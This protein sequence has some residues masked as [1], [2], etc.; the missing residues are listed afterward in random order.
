[1]HYEITRTEFLC[2]QSSN[3]ASDMQAGLVVFGQ[4]VYDASMLA[5]YK[6]NIS[7]RQH[8][9]DTSN[10]ER[11]QSLRPSVHVLMARQCPKLVDVGRGCD[12]GRDVAR[13]RPA[14]RNE[15]KMNVV[16]LVQ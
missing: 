2:K 10:T 7:Y 8:T 9:V 13:W 12:L 15:K 11:L 4:Q 16:L 14:Y 3:L 5:T 6:T 1:M